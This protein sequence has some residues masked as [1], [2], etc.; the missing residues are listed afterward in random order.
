MLL[1]VKDVIDGAFK[2]KSSNFERGQYIVERLK[3]IYNNTSYKFCCIVVNSVYI[4]V[5]IFIITNLF[6][7]NAISKEN[8]LFFGVENK[9]NFQI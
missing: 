7:L 6:I 8:L 4:L 3:A 9:D 1:N 5:L 2:Y